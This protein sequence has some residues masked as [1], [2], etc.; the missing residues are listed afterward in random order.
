[1]Q[2]PSGRW[3]LHALCS[4][5]RLPDVHA[6]LSAPGPC[7]RCS[8]RWGVCR[9][10][11]WARAW[12]SRQRTWE[13]SR[14]ALARHLHPIFHERLRPVLSFLL[15]LCHDVSSCLRAGLISALHATAYYML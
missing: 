15:Q 13:P 2:S 5:G 12:T 14:R 7:R 1:M 4:Q 11:L 9:L 8:W 3:V 6:R 10:T